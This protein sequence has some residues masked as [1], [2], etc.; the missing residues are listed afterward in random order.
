MKK[1]LSLLA[2][3]SII[4]VVG[5]E[6][7][8]EKGNYKEGTYFGSYEYESYGAKY[9][10]TSVIYV[11]EKS[12]IASVF[13]DSTYKK[14]DVNTTKKVL[15]DA[16]GMKS[17]SANNGVIAGGAEWYEQVQKIEEK[18]IAEQGISWLVMDESNKT[19]SVSGVT[20]T[21]DSYY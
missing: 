21:V 6:K 17:T 15:G 13:V 10:T 3:I 14:D 7:V 4:C 18:T 9:V 8:E 11:N 16:Y 2:I 19:D 5:C 12:K 1:I 20:I